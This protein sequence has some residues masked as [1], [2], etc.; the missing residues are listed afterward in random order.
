[1]GRRRGGIWKSGM[2]KEEGWD[3]EGWDREGKDGG[4]E[5]WDEE[6]G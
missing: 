2:G 1:M 5:R 4:R 6:E 3:R